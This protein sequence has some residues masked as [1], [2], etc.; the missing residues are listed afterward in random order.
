MVSRE[1]Y[2]ADELR[3][4][5]QTLL[6]KVGTPARYAGL[7]AEALLDADIE[8]LGSHGLMLLPMYLERIE[9]GSVDAGA[10][11]EI[12]V[13]CGS[14]L[15]IDAGNALGHISAEKAAALAIDRAR[16]HG[17]A[18]V[19]VRNAFH[20]GAAGRFARKIALAGQIGIVMANT[21]PLLPAPGGAERVVGNNPLAIAVPTGGEPLVLDLA[22]SAGAMGKIRL[23]EGRGEPIPEGWAATADG[24]PTTNATEAIKGMLLPAAGA[25][26]FGLAVMVDLLAGGLSAGAIGDA[27]RPL[28]GDLSQPYGSAN[29][30]LAIQVEGLRPRD[31]FE[32]AANGFADRIRGSKV[33]PGVAQVRMP[34]D[35]AAK[36]HRDFDGTCR[37][38]PATMDA[39]RSAAA[40]LGVAFPSSLS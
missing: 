12:V 34:G 35:R 33:A 19:A 24:V 29:L 27:V 1:S 18:A 2:P 10:A 20:F 16:V 13:D 30:F 32:A 37:V 14:R 31:E 17:L 6:V 7:V 23:A 40:R 15:T 21:R 36:A 22:M 9:K 5:A 25:K 26:G 11:G 28:Y 39:L 4:L 8:G 3:M 38:A